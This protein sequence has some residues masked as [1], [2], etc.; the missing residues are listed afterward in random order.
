MC[1]A[2]HGGFYGE[3]DELFHLFSSQSSRFGHDDY[4]GGCQVG[5]HVHFRVYGS[6]SS[7][8]EQQ[9]GGNE[10]HDAVVEGEVYDFVEHVG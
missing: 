9:H 3:G 4:R 8:N 5:K 6:I 1:G 2:I 7:A 10:Y